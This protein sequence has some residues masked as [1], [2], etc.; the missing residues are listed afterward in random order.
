MPNLVRQNLYIDTAQPWF[1]ELVSNHV[2]VAK[3]KGL[4]RLKWSDVARRGLDDLKAVSREVF[5]SLVS[6]LNLRFNVAICRNC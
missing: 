1:K 2:M 4:D 5:N 3:A 6:H